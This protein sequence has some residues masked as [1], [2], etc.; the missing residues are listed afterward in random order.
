MGQAQPLWKLNISA[1]TVFGG[2]TANMTT[3]LGAQYND[4]PNVALNDVAVSEFAI[5][6]FDSAFLNENRDFVRA[7]PIDGVEVN[8]T[9]ISNGSYPLARPLL[10][11]SSTSIMNESPQVAE[12]I[13]YYLQNLD[14]EF[15]SYNLFPASVPTQQVAANTWLSAMGQDIE[16]EPLVVSTATPVP[17][18]IT[19]DPEPTEEPIFEPVERE[20]VSAFAADVLPLL[21][22]ARTDLEV[23]ATEELGIQRPPGWSGSLDVN[24]PQLALLTRLDLE[25]LAA[26]VY[27][28]DNRPDEWFG[29]VGSSQLAVVRDIRHDIEIMAD[30]VYNG[31]RPQDWAGGD[32]IYRCSRSTQALAAVLERAGIY[33]VQTNPVAIDYCEQVEVEIARFSEVNLL[34]ENSMTIIDEGEAEVARDYEISTEFAIAFLTRFAEPQVGVI[35]LMTPVTPVARSYAVGSNMTLIEGNGYRVFIEFTNTTISEEQWEDLP[36][37]DDIDEIVTFCD[38]IWCR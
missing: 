15:P 26:I 2:E 37:I 11:Y 13:K 22:N 36:N 35:P 29:A 16:P 19:I 1:Q 27:G 3:A 32:P 33:T 18:V 6:I 30:T 14:F 21:I 4:D 20:P 17:E 31:A 24:D 9:S 23:M 5:G 12:F 8:F 34:G 28:A 7:I 25:L 10:L 38:A